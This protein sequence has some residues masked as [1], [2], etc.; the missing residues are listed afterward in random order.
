[1]VN[2][3][4]V[5]I[6][7]QG[8]Y[9]SN[10]PAGTSTS[11]IGIEVFNVSNVTI[12]N[13][14]IVGFNQGIHLEG[15]GKLNS[16]VVDSVRFTYNTSFAITLAGSRNAIIRNCQIASTGYDSTNAVIPGS[17]GIAIFDVNSN[18]G[19]LIIGNNISGATGEG[20]ILGSNDLADG[21]LITNTPVGIQGNDIT[22]KLKNNT[23]N[24]SNTPYIGG[25]QLPGTNF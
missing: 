11:A 7:L 15:S 4:N 16:T 12:Q 6:D 3:G 17:N 8:S 9:I 13:G 25:T 19:N 14:F 20:M 10:L 1:M 24:L 18:G 5:T 23:V 22:S 21:N 2:T